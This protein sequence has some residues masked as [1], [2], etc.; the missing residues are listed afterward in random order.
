MVNFFLGKSEQYIKCECACQDVR[1]AGKGKETLL[2]APEITQV[3]SIPLGILK[4]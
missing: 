2:S 4:G 1:D 3:P